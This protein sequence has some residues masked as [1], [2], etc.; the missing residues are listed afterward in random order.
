MG[1]KRG[2]SSGY[3]CVSKRESNQ[4]FLLLRSLQT[5]V[6]ASCLEDTSYGTSFIGSIGT[7]VASAATESTADAASVTQAQTSRDSLSAVSLDDEASQLTQY[8]RSY[9][10]AA[11]VFS[12]VNE[13]YATVLNLG[14][15]TTVS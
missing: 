12:I 10:A 6:R 13:M 9:E 14:E 4:T 15:E 2:C 5:A 3:L 11:K 8:Q 7:T 1:C